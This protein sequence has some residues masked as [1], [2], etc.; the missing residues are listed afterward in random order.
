MI[1]TARAKTH[2]KTHLIVGDGTTAVAFLEKCA[3]ESGD[4]LILLGKN[5][6]EL[7]RGAA[8]AK[9]EAG[10]PWRYAYLLNSPA[11]DID[12]EFARW[13]SDNWQSIQSTMADRT[14]N[15]LASAQP[16]VD[17][18]NI[19]GLN[20]PREFY[21]DFMVEHTEKVL[22][23][24][25]IKGV[26]V[27]LINDEA[28]A[29][30][31]SD[32][33]NLVQTNANGVIYADSADIAP[34]GPSTL[35]IEGDEGAFAVPNVFGFEAQIAEHIKAGREIFCI[36][37]N[38]A[39]LDVLRLCQSLLP[40]ADVK[41]AFCAPDGE[42]PAALIP[43]LPR[44]LTIP[45]FSKGHATAE[46][47]LKEVRREIDAALARGDEMREIRAGFRAHFLENPL[48][49]YITNANE[50]RIV[51]ATL[52]F[53]LRGG[54]RDTIQDLHGFIKS[55]QARIVTG[56]VQ[57]VEHGADGATVHVI[58][59]SG[60]VTQDETGFVINTAGAGPNS[61]YDPLTEDMLSKGLIHNCPISK[62]LKV[63]AGLRTALPSVRHLSPATTVIGD[64]VMAMPLYDVHMLRHFVA[65]A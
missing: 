13:L 11:D 28:T 21:G 10:T 46:S 65:K 59:A 4:R 50:A 14:P 57:K 61:R 9:G 62:G 31:T 40:D 5:I 43:R 1:D 35:R 53:W 29:I 52:R 8:Y 55:G 3:L 7:G 20:A 49:A 24:L 27:E 30:D 45:S 32:A 18:G 42:V 60:A 56:L 2:A 64:E 17:A 63:G 47:F 25:R 38:A 6:A 41:L 44:K 23:A 39:M 36:G 26:Q 54:T 16:L 19:H 34:G 22:A 58:D 37:G 12:R 48:S 15:W 51:P 33:G